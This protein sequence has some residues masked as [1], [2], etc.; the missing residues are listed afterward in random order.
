MQLTWPSAALVNPAAPSVWCMHGWR[1][2]I[3]K[4]S[5]A[6]LAWRL[7]PRCFLTAEGCI[8]PT[9]DLV[10]FTA[11]TFIPASHLHMVL[12]SRILPF[13][14]HGAIAYGLQSMCAACYGGVGRCG[15]G[16]GAQG[17]WAILEHAIMHAPSMHGRAVVVAVV[18]ATMNTCSCRVVSCAGLCV[19][20]A[21]LLCCPW[22]LHIAAWCLSAS[23]CAGAW[24]T[25][26]Q[27]ASD[28]AG[29]QRSAGSVVMGF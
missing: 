10:H 11:S 1:Q 23:G 4:A 15:W 6:W 7:L 18:A 21:V 20:A 25:C 8:I 29:S 19:P 24:V 17:A 22:L 9:C 13:V 28:A 26:L 27:C 16:C 12:L 14:V 5:K 2:S 3:V